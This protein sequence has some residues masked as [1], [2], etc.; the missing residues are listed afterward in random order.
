MKLSSIS[1]GATTVVAP[2][3]VG[4]ITTKGQMKPTSWQGEFNGVPARREQRLGNQWPRTHGRIQCFIWPDLQ[5][6]SRKKSSIVWTIIE[7]GRSAVMEQSVSK[8]KIN[9]I[10]ASTPTSILILNFLF[11]PRWRSAALSPPPSSPVNDTAVTS[12]APSLPP[13]FFL[14][15]SVSALISRSVISG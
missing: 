8:F 3:S 6:K 15:V 10:I 4:S 14:L 1:P 11:A 7:P 9:T 12:L 2:K 5:K 13:A